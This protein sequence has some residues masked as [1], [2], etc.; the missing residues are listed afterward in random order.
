MFE[1]YVQEVMVDNQEVELSL[2]DTAGKQQQQQQ[3][4][5]TQGLDI[6]L[7]LL[8]QS[9]ETNLLTSIIIDV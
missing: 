6:S 5:H 4:Q 1:N 9:I 3:Q 2:W 7:V 8:Y